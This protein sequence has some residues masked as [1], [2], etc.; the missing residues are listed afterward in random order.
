MRLILLGL[1]VSFLLITRSSQAAEQKIIFNVE[2]MKGNR[3]YMDSCRAS[4]TDN[5]KDENVSELMKDGWSI[6][7]SFQKNEVVDSYCTCVGTQYV[8][9][10]NNSESKE[11]LKE[12]NERLKVEIARLNKENESLKAKIK[13]KQKK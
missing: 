11:L 6:V 5:Y 10:K 12:E 4:C 8:M 1:T 3:N 9:Q 13:A 7:N 2:S